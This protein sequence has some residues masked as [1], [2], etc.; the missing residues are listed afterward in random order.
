MQSEWKRFGI[1][2]DQGMIKIKGKIMIKIT[3]NN[4]AILTLKRIYHY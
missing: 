1:K 2:K 3:A 4:N